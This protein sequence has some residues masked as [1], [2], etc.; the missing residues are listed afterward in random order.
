MNTEIKKR[1]YA[2]RTKK[3]GQFTP[4]EKYNLQK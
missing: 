4:M 3:L 2:M 1:R